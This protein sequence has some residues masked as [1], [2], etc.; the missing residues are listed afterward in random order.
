MRI[1][2]ATPFADVYSQT[3]VWAH[4]NRLS[5]VVG[6]LVGCPVEVGDKVEVAGAAARLRRGVKTVLRSA[7]LFT[8]EQQRV[9]DLVRWLRKRRV[10]VILA[11]FGPTAVE[12]EEAARIAKLPLVAHFHGHDASE[13]RC[14][15]Q[16]QEGY[17]RLFKTAA[18]IIGVSRPMLV[19]LEAQGAP[20]ER[21]HLIPYGIDLNRFARG[22]P[23]QQSPHFI[24]VGRFVEKKAPQLTLLAFAKIAQQVPGTHLT[25]VGDGPLLAPCKEMALAMDLTQ[26]VSF[27][28]ALSHEE[29]ACLMRSARAF[30]QHSIQPE[31]GDCEGTPVAI[32]E[33]SA[34]GLPVI[35][36]RHAGIPEAVLDGETGFLVNERD[37]EVMAARMHVLATQPHLA[38]EM[39][40]K[41]RRHVTENYEMER[42]I[43][44]L[45]DLL[46][47]VAAV[48][49][50]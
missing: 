1:A 39:G 13:K 4:I 18:A 30:V 49:D 37:I 46:R 16:Y 17:T 42:Q 47:S 38:C 28:G 22:K 20:R 43:Q 32:L 15:E 19:A 26:Q 5:G 6:T 3:F 44:R 24:A 25:M 41:G 11:E 12:M 23:S 2:V 35:G 33:A 40:K 36:T 34:S 31:N 29:V 27:P 45:A 48:N 14:L 21:L 9:G 8:A 7:G 10:S 50:R